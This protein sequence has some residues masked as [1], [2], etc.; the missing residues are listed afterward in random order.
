MQG[1]IPS[2]RENRNGQESTV[3]CTTVG[4]T[5]LDEYGA[6]VFIIIAVVAI[7]VITLTIILAVILCKCKR[8]K[9]ARE[10]EPLNGV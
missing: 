4:R 10:K 1:T 7:A 3:L 2:R 6:E 9:N 5:I 8:A